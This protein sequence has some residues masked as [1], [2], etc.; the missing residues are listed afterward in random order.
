MVNLLQSY[1]VRIQK[2]VFEAYLEINKFEKLKKAIQS[3]LGN[4]SIES[5]KIYR[6]KGTSETFS[7]GNQPEYDLEPDMRTK[8]ANCFLKRD[9]QPKVNNQAIFKPLRLEKSRN[10]LRK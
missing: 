8:L 7:Y 1:G 2:S 6:L 5:V 4:E 9:L 3:L 10:N